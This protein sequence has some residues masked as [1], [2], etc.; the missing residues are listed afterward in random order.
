M[1]WCVFV[2]LW[3]QLCSAVLN[4]EPRF[5]W[6]DSWILQCN[7]PIS[8]IAP[9]C[10][11]YLPCNFISMD[12]S[13]YLNIDSKQTYFLRI[14]GDWLGNFNYGVCLF[15]VSKCFIY[16]NHTVLLKKLEMYGITST[17]WLPLG[18]WTNFQITSCDIACGVPQGSVLG[19]ILLLSFINGISNLAVG[20]C[21]QNKHDDDVAI[22]TPTTSKD[23][24]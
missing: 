1:I 24:I 21:V 13:T 14:M 23:G 3:Y 18:T 7:C 6:P 16:I 20:D 5:N 2:R 19:P 12:Q 4:A 22:Y 9:F 11:W 17:K 15:Y 10:N 8:H